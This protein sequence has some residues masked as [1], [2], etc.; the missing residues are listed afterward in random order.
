MHTYSLQNVYTYYKIFIH[1]HITICISTYTLQNVHTQLHCLW[2]IAH[3]TNSLGKQKAGLYVIRWCRAKG[4]TSTPLPMPLYC[5]VTASLSLLWRHCCDVIVT[6]S[7]VL[8]WH[9]FDYKS[10]SSSQIITFSLFCFYALVKK[11]CT[12]FFRRTIVHNHW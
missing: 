12:F 6:A 7:L 11:F 3:R 10:R 1:I 9:N 5:D 8:L 4:R 2:S